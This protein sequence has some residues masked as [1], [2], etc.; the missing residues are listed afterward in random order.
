[1][2]PFTIHKLEKDPKRK[3]M[4]LLLVFA[5]VMVSVAAACAILFYPVTAIA[6]DHHLH[7]VVDIPPATKDILKF[8]TV[9]YFATTIISTFVSSIRRMK[10]LGIAF[11]LSYVFTVVFY[12]GTVVSIC[13]LF[14]FTSQCCCI[15]DNI[16]VAGNGDASDEQ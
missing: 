13:V 3:K 11:L 16:R 12:S 8:F 14:C 15:L 2:D 1:M 10:W 7:Y 9:L 6:A 4:L 5:G